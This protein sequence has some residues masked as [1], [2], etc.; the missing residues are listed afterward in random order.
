MWVGRQGW[1]SLPR[2]EDSPKEEARAPASCH[3]VDVQLRSLEGDTSS[4][5]LKHVLELPSIAAHVRGCS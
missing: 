5:G 4:A 3:C 2:S 1:G